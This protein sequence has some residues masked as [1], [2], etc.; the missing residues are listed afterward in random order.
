MLRFFPSNYRCK[1]KFEDYVALHRIVT[2]VSSY[3]IW[4]NLR[5]HGKL[6][7]SFLENVPDEF[8]DWVKKVE[9]EVK[10]QFRFT[11]SLHAA[12]VSSVL[13]SGLDDRKK[14]AEAFMA[15]KDPRINYGILFL[16]ADGRDPDPKIWN[17]V[18]PEYSRPFAN[19]GEI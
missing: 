5:D 2:Q 14:M 4:E 13:R 9:S 3:D 10:E 18:K 1:I 15:V 8:Y 11:K 19:K 17:M 7:E 12:H 16:I 6:P